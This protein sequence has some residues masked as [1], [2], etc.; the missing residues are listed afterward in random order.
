[1]PTKA[2]P[3]KTQ[4]HSLF[5]FLVIAVFVCAIAVACILNYSTAAQNKRKA[6]EAESQYSVAF[7]KNE[8]L[9]S[10]LNDEE[11]DEYYEQIAR[12]KYGYAK[13]GERVFYYDAYDATEE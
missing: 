2:T 13:P 1:M 3:K 4:K 9:E 5:L 11:H 7:S 8:E 10:F 6:Q 12:E